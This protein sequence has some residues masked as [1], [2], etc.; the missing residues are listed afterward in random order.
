MPGAFIAFQNNSDQK[1]FTTQDILS[2]PVSMI[3]NRDRFGHAQ[4]RL[5]LD[6][7][8]TL[9]QLKNNEYEHYE[10]QL[11]ANSIKKW[12]LNDDSRSKASGIK[13]DKF[14]I[15]NAEDLKNTDFACVA[16]GADY[17]KTD[18][19]FSY[20]EEDLTLTLQIENGMIDPF[21]MR[22][23]YFGRTDKDINLCAPVSDKSYYHTKDF[24]QIDLTKNSV[25]I[26]LVNSNP[27]L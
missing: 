9:S 16:N 10:F 3:A 11:S 4:G 1:S 23:I 25:E 27:V 20:S 8:F 7:G 15:T 17:S 24:Q 19:K 26:E 12:I 14:V 13:I 2:K 21:T 6:D 18:L 22:D 5:F